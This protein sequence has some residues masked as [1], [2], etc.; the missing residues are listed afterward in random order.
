ML[1]DDSGMRLGDKVAHR[2]RMPMIAPRHAVVLVQALLHHRPLAVRRYDKTMKI[3]LKSVGDRI[4][5]DPRGKPAGPDQGV[6]VEAPSIG[7][8]PQLLR[9][10]AREPAATATNIDAKLRRARR[11]SALERAP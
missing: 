11:K 5:V 9:R 3:D 1:A 10:V 4:V 7:H 6:A 8:G 2:S